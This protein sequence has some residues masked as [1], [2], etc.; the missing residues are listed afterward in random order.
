MKK[1]ILLLLLTLGGVARAQ[2]S[3]TST[4]ATAGACDGTIVVEARGPAGPFWLEVSG[5]DGYVRLFG[6]FNGEQPIEDLCGG[7]YTVNIHN[8]FACL[9][10]EIVEVPC[11][12]GFTYEAANPCRVDGGFIEVFPQGGEPPYSYTWRYPDGRMEHS[13]MIHPSYAGRFCVTITDANGCTA[14]GCAGNEP[15]EME[16]SIPY[17]SEVEAVARGGGYEEVIYRGR[18]REAAAGCVVYQGGTW[19]I[20]DALL[21]DMHSGQ[22]T[23][24]IRATSNEE[25]TTLELSTAHLSRRSGQYAAGR[26][27]FEASGAEVAGMIENNEIFEQLVFT[28]EDAA[29]NILLDFRALS[30]YLSDCIDIP[31]LQNDCSWTGVAVT[32]KDQVHVIRKSCLNLDIT[33]DHING[34]ISVD[35]TNQAGPFSYQWTDATGQIIGTEAV[36][37]NISS[38]QYCI[39][40]TGA[41]CSAAE[42]VDVCIAKQ[43]KLGDYLTIEQPCLGQSNGRICLSKAADEWQV[44]WPDGTSGECMEDVGPGQYYIDFINLRC[45]HLS[46]TKLI[47]LGA[48]SEPLRIHLSGSFPSCNGEG[49]GELCVGASGGKPP[50]VFSWA[51][52]AESLCRVDLPAGDCYA[53]TVTDRC[54]NTATECFEIPAYE[55]LVIESVNASNEC[56][57][58]SDGYLG[59]AEVIFS[60][61]R[62]PFE[63]IWQGD[64]NGFYETTD[65]PRVQGLPKGDYLVTIRDLSCG[66]E[67][68]TASAA[69]GVLQSHGPGFEILADDIMEACSADKASGRIRLSIVPAGTYFFKWSH[70]AGR[71]DVEQ[72]LP[73]SYTVTVTNKEGCQRIQ[74]FEVGVAELG[75][76]SIVLQSCENSIVDVRVEGGRSPYSYH[77]SNGDR[78]EDLVGVPSGNYTVTVSDAR[79]CYL[80]AAYELAPVF[81]EF[82]YEVTH[83]RPGEEEG[84]V[85]VF[86]EGI[87]GAPFTIRLAGKM[88]E[89]SRTG[90]QAGETVLFSDLAAGQYTVSLEN[91]ILCKAIANIEIRSCEERNR[92][93]EILDASCGL[94]NGAIFPSAGIGE[95]QWNTGERTRVLASAPGGE[96][97]LT[98]TDGEGCSYQHFFVGEINARVLEVTNTGIGQAGRAAIAF[99]RSSPAD[100]FISFLKAFSAEY[101]LYRGGSLVQTGQIRE[102]DFT[103]DGVLFFDELIAGD[104][105]LE[106]SNG[107][108]GAP[109]IECNFIYFSVGEC[110][111]DLISDFFALE[112]DARVLIESPSAPG[113]LDG[114][115]RVEVFYRDL[116]SGE[117]YSPEE[118]YQPERPPIH[119]RW[120]GPNGFGAGTSNIDRLAEGRYCLTIS[121]GCRQ[122]EICRYIAYCGDVALSYELYQFSSREEICFYYTSAPMNVVLNMENPNGTPVYRWSDGAFGATRSISYEEAFYQQPRFRYVVG[123]VDEAGCEAETEIGLG[124]YQPPQDDLDWTM[125]GRLSQGE[126]AD[127]KVL[128]VF[129]SYLLNNGI[130]GL[131]NPEPFVTG[132]ERMILCEGDAEPTTIARFGLECQAIRSDDIDAW[133]VCEY[134]TFAETLHVKCARNSEKATQLRLLTTHEVEISSGAAGCEVWLYA[135]YVDVEFGSYPFVFRKKLYGRSCAGDTPDPNYDPYKEI[136]EDCEAEGGLTFEYHPDNC[137]RDIICHG[138]YVG[139]ESMIRYVEE[140][141]YR[142]E[143]CDLTGELIWE[144][145][146]LRECKEVDENGQCWRVEMCTWSGEVYS[147]E[148][149]SD[150]S[151]L[152]GCEAAAVVSWDT[153]SSV[154]ERSIIRRGEAESFKTTFTEHHTDARLDRS[155]EQ[156]RCQIYPNPFA[157]EI[158]IL[159]DI[160]ESGDCRVELYD[161]LGQPVFLQRFP[162]EPGRRLYSP[163]LPSSLAAG[164]YHVRVETPDH[165]VFLHKLIKITE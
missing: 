50:Y 163:V 113:A 79:Q 149:L 71:E 124:G 123:A 147:L 46:V 60:G 82:S 56:G 146:G 165:T 141:C 158:K 122:V 108:G 61:G 109:P 101:R 29:G 110:S 18:W 151:S 62:G 44:A 114:A 128:S 120:E 36:L 37:K 65:K 85:A 155:G 133:E 111:N 91:N 89:E 24:E 159:V 131:S 127:R 117:E 58:A 55:P 93:A 7:T 130:Y 75:L 57:S 105:R 31:R 84:V 152:A 2:I 94:P 20:S 112:L 145:S 132:C 25:L 126:D 63:Y 92:D 157:S 87:P 78:T 153:R 121:D 8:R 100:G 11:S 154:G 99:E 39:E 66:S 136:K 41:G 106:V 27:I 33:A 4:A 118:I 51:D 77:W 17:L 95:Y 35:V 47:K 45:D 67:V 23:L 49:N 103:G 59:S 98:V 70:G 140:D 125:S 119:Y 1:A 64:R 38:G 68:V 74:T 129:R 160:R 86:T 80:T 148:P 48:I 96:Y 30:P 134:V 164:L 76:E 104:Y 88:G 81:D 12:F 69:F 73:G 156:P 137:T 162:A 102:S 139:T 72:L 13:K 142:A 138:A 21:S 90:I 54:G 97:T 6:N 135:L 22:V 34:M 83:T 28:G 14:E 107:E 16:V 116:T 144:Q 115:F 143:I 26:W 52:G 9:S 19:E 5:P 10:T 3:V 40:V 32:G 161:M 53:V 43:D 15:E 42:C 150:C